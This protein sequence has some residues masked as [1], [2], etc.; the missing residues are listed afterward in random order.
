MTAVEYFRRWGVWP[1][2]DD[3]ARVSCEQAGSVGHF[4]CGVCPEHD[5]P[6]FMCGCVCASSVLPPAR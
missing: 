6:R 2:L 5:K 1:E 4:H 3:L